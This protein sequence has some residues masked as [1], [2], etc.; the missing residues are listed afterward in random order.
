MSV[1]SGGA[2]DSPL[3]VKMRGAQSMLGECS[4]KHLY[5][6]IAQCELDSLKDGRSRKVTV[7]SIRAY[8]ARRV[9]AAKEAEK[10]AAVHTTSNSRRRG[11]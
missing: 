4:R 3:V 1:R 7:A 8:I 5:A 10:T 11:K 2:S 6:L 9:E